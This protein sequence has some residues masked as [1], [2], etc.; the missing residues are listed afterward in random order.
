MRNEFHTLF[1]NPGGIIKPKTPFWYIWCNSQ[2][3]VRNK[4]VG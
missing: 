3:P 4:P 2:I 1:H